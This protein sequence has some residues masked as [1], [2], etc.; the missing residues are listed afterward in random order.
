MCRRILIQ[1][2]P[3][4][5]LPMQAPYV[6]PV[7]PTPQGLAQRPGVRQQ[8]SLSFGLQPAVLSPYVPLGVHPYTHPLTTACGGCQQAQ[9]EIFSLGLG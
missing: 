7:A 8:P 1:A 4:P 3:Q 5:G 6:P 9:G 2:V